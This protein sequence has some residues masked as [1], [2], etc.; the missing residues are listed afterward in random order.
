MEVYVLPLSLAQRQIWYQEI[1]S[2]GSTAYNIPIALRLV[3]NVDELALEKSFRQIIE[4]HEVLRTTF[5]VEEGVPVQLIHEEYKFS[6]EKK[7]LEL[8]LEGAEESLRKILET[9]SQ[10]PFDLV[11]DQLMR[12][13][14]YQIS[15]QEHILLVNL[16]HIIS[17]GWSLGLLVKE[18]TEFYSTFVQGKKVSL[19][20]LPIQYGDYAEWQ[21]NW[22]ESE[23]IQQQLAY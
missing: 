2:S 7:I 6:L 23:P 19:P 11:K 18:L 8:P 14:L 22:L 20:E 10:R 9:E 5:A 15:K 12:I 13:V 17:D 3:G 16:H 4:R 1:V 21:S